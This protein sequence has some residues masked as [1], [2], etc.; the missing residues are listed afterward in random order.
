MN[1]LEDS[2]FIICTDM[3]GRQ[4][5]IS[6]RCDY[7]PPH[8]LLAVSEVL[9]SGADKYGVENWHNVSPYEHL[10]RCIRHALRFFASGDVVELKNSA[11]RCLM[12]LELFLLTKEQ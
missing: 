11:C 10:G 8:A 1:V 4:S 6:E 5:F 3:G 2:E 7:L 9:A 12:A